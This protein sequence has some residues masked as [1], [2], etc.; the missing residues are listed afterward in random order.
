MDLLHLDN[1]LD[2]VGDDPVLVIAMD[3]WTDA[4]EGGTA[5]ATVL[6]DSGPR[7]HLGGFDGDA[8]F[9]F[10]DRRPPLEIDRGV[11]GEPQWP[12]L[13]VDLVTPP[14]GPPLLLVHGAEPDL[15]W[16]TIAADLLELCELTGARRYVGLGAVPGPIPHTRPVQMVCTSNDTV[17]LERIG[18]PHE[19]VVVP[20]SCQVAVEATLGAAGIAT[21]GLWARIPHYVAG[22]YPDGARALLEQVSSHL[23]TPV[24][25][26]A[27]Q[28][29]AAENRSRLDLAASGSQEVSEHVAQLERLYDA[30]AEAERI[31]T[32][33][34]D[35]AA[36]TEEQVPSAEELGAEI[37]RFLRGRQD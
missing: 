37:E 35:D 16:R 3:G 30:E 2:T 24:D 9:D 5:A 18:R 15:R 33:R 25:L 29:A 14:G 10:R 22:D 7:R 23:G 21:L 6:R 34:G 19:Q 17:L 32:A 12:T 20:S 1:P 4:G 36:I 11:L 28:V 27:L 13:D 8:V 31:V 26:T